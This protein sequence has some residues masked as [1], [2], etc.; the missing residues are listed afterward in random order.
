M[1]NDVSAMALVYG[2]KESQKRAGVDIFS[3][4]EIERLHREFSNIK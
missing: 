2:G 3:Y 4:R 1:G